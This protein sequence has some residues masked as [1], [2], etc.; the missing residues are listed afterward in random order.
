MGV[1]PLSAQLTAMG[2]LSSLLLLLAG[3]V[4][5]WATRVLLASLAFW[6]PGAEPTVLYSGF[7]QLGRYPIDIY[8]P[9]VRGLLIY[10][11]PVAFISSIPARAD[12]RRRPWRCWRWG[13]RRRWAPRCWRGRPGTWGCGATPARPARTTTVTR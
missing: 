4:I 5:A 1:A 13:S 12:P 3:T 10:V 7:W 2:A 6:A 11:V 8:H 9:I